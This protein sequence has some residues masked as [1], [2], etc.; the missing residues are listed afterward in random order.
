MSGTVNGPVTARESHLGRRCRVGN[1][2][3]GVDAWWPASR[4]AV[5]AD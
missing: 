3:N 5:G 2:G 4:P 1:R